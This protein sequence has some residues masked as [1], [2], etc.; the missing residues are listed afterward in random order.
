LIGGY[1]IVSKKALAAGASPVGVGG[2]MK[3]VA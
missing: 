1:R 2:E 3:S